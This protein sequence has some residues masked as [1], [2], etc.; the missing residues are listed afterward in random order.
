MTISKRDDRA[1]Q[2]IEQRAM[3]LVIAG[4]LALIVGVTASAQAQTSGSF[5]RE[6]NMDR[7][8]NDIRKIELEASQEVGAC[9]DLCRALSDCKAFTY[10]KKSTTVPRPICRLKDTTPTAHES[11]CCTSGVRE[12]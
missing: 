9:E 12:K 4:A 11:S 3:R 2:S 6:P 7:S 1:G 5:T 10:V 8:G